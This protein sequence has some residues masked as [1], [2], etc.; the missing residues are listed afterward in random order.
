MFGERFLSI[1]AFRGLTIAAMVLVNNPGSWSHIYPPLRHAEWHGWTPTDLV[2]PFFL[3]I[4]GLSMTFSFGRRLRENQAPSVL[5]PK[6]LKRTVVLFSLGLMLHLIPSFSLA[7][8]RIPGVLQR[9][10]LGY[11]VGS[12]IYLKT[13]FSSRF[14]VSV[15]FLAGYT[16][17]LLLVPVPGYG[18]GVLEPS[19]NLP[20]YL[21]NLLLPGHLYRPGFDPE[22]LLSTLPAV[23]T[24]LFGTFL[25]D[26]LRSSGTIVRK[27]L[28]IFSAGIPLAA[29]GLLLHSWHP[30]NKPLWTVSYVLFT[31]GM[32][33]LVFGMCFL[34]IDVFRLKLWARPFLILGSNAIVVFVG[35]SLLAKILG[36]ISLSDG[37]T[38]VGLA[39][40]LQTH[41]FSLLGGP[42]L[43]S[44]AW[45]VLNVLLWI[46]LTA[47][48]YKHR[49]FLK[50]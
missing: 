37:A 2:F 49:L 33:H 19:G 17:L 44:L 41:V 39:A 36:L 18:A 34:L 22:G 4:M 47:P 43:A 40:Y 16:A 15:A 35:S 26:F 30:I 28:I 48:L 12:L 20:G 38:A 9:I 21:D 8:L 7:H 31:A 23:V 1:D 13:R 29:A 45:A 11:L 5:Y 32:A 14:V 27:S 3:F 46:A 6:I 25:G 24:V 42:K 50:I 10:A